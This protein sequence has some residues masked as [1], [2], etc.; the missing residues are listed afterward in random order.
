MKYHL[1][2]SFAAALIAVAHPAAAAIVTVS[3]S[4][5]TPLGNSITLDIDGVGRLGYGVDVTKPII[6]GAY[7]A[8]IDSV[9]GYTNG[10]RAAW[11]YENYGGLVEAGQAV[12]LAL[13]DLMNDGADGLS[14]GFVRVGPSVSEATR[15]LG[16]SIIAASVGQSSDN[17]I[18]LRLSASGMQWQSLITA[19]LPSLA[20]ALDVAEVPE[21][22]TLIMLAAGLC[23][24]RCYNRRSWRLN[25]H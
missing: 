19:P 14:A 16:E 2:T 10:Q 17:A 23:L 5:P 8:E 20:G 6:F 21:P 12:Q 4:G 3:G 13:W 7:Q 22:G 9:S 1:L 18:I 15:S 11:I 25:S 24:G